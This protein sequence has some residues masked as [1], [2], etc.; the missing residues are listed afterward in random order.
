MLKKP[1]MAGTRIHIAAIFKKFQHSLETYLAIHHDRSLYRS[2]PGGV[3]QALSMPGSRHPYTV[4]IP[5]HLESRM[6]T[7]FPHAC[8]HAIG[9]P[10][11]L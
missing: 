8:L 1:L 11:L 9:P 5:R 3:K 7:T 4:L 2:I 6:K 10:A